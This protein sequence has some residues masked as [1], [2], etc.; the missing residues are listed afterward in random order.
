MA[1]FA[2]EKKGVATGFETKAFEAVERDF[3]EVLQDL[4]GDK[5]LER[6]RVE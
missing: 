2:D 3:Q 5:S 4:T 6:F 1:D